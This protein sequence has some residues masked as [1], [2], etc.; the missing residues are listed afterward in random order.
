MPKAVKKGRP[1]KYLDVYNEQARKLGLLG[2]TDKEMAAFFC[3]AESTFNLWKKQYPIFSESL[4]AGKDLAD[5][6]VTASL[7]ERAKGYSHKETKV[8]NHQGEIITHDVTRMYPP[9]PMAIKYWL[10][11][12]QPKRW[13]EKVEHEESSA[14]DSLTKVLIEVVGASKD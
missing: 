14:V 5:M 6:E 3:V 8:F 11:N 7:Y 1:K 12:R 2:Y 10:N 4:K 9:D 13:R